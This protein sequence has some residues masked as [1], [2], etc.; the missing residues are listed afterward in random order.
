[1]TTIPLK[2]ADFDYEFPPELVAQKPA[3][4]RDESRLLVRRADGTIG[5]RIFKD[6]PRCLPEKTLLVL[7]DTSVLQSRLHGFL[8]TGARVEIFLLE[9]VSGLTWRAMAKPLRKLRQGTMILFSG[10]KKDTPEPN[11]QL[12]RGIVRK[13]EKAPDGEVPCLEIEFTGDQKSGRLDFFSWLERVGET[14]LPPYIPRDNLHRRDPEDRSRYETVFAK[15]K[16]SVAAP[17]AGLHFTKVV[18]EDLAK[19]GIQLASVTLHV[20]GG[21]FLPVR[22]EEVEKH[23][24]H[25]EF[26]MVPLETVS[27]VLSAKKSGA[28]ICCVGT[29]S[30]RAIESLWKMSDERGIPPEELAGQ[31][32][33]TS[34]F[35]HPRSIEDRFHPLVADAILTN[36]H[37]PKSTLFMLISALI[38]LENA[39]SMYAS[40][41]Q[42]RYRLFS[43]GDSTLLFLHD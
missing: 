35:I 20:G 27:A 29:T 5:H 16:G 22:Q 8:P 21:T 9:Q 34:L 7:N 43:Y 3:E 41:I 4:V 38:G 15:V 30:F 18:L 32:H 36:F 12:V 10:E 24:I 14:P 33:E 17:T 13:I 2:L 19:S 23:P 37:Q 11:S 28:T 1:M 6:L 39:K 40:A 42:K 31:W 25:K 26:F